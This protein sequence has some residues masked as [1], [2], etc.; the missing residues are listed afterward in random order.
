MGALL[1]WS[2]G[3]RDWQRRRTL[4]HGA[5][6]TGQSRPGAG[7]GAAEAQGLR[8]SR[9]FEFHILFIPLCKML[10]IFQFKILLFAP[11]FA[12]ELSQGL[13]QLT[14]S[15]PGVH[16]TPALAAPSQCCWRSRSS[17]AAPPR[18]EHLIG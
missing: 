3:S 4:P 12:A 14:A 1:F 17:L 15:G 11:W 8:F 18:R 2:C 13:G 5:E 6:G 10:E 9:V 7:L 16:G